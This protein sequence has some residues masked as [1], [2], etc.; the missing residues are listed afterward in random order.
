ML[1]QLDW[2]LGA[3]VNVTFRCSRKKYA[4][5]SSTPLLRPLQDIYGVELPERALTE[6]DIIAWNI[7][8]SWEVSGLP[9]LLGLC[10]QG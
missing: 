2:A 10:N 5:Q 8:G 4:H 1:G 6:N 7:E 9:G 3:D